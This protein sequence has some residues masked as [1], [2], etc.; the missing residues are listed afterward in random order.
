[1]CNCSFLVVGGSVVD[2]GFHKF[3]LMQP[4]HIDCSQSADWA[5]LHVLGPLGQGHNMLNLE[6]PCLTVWLDL[7]AVCNIYSGPPY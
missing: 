3:H 7:G 1:M 5:A 4:S 6:F 2:R